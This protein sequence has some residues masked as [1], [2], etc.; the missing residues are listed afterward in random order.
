MTETIQPHSC[1]TSVNV[2]DKDLHLQKPET[3]DN[4]SPLLTLSQNLNDLY[5]NMSW[6][7]YLVKEYVSQTKKLEE[8]LYQK[9]QEE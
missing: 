8:I 7:N 2:T 5:K 3:K 9:A 6:L 4:M 1:K